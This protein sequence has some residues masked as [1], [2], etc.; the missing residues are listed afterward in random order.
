MNKYLRRELYK[1]A[2]FG[3]TS[4]N[5]I[6]SAHPEALQ[7]SD[8]SQQL[9]S[10]SG[11]K[12]KMDKLT[13]SL[14]SKNLAIAGLIGLIAGAALMGRKKETKYTFGGNANDI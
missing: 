12:D 6:M 8:L 10:L 9:K 3:M 11:G 5:D 14:S 2:L 1:K 7:I 13:K 4:F